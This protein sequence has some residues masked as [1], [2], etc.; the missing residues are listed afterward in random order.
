RTK[1]FGFG[2]IVGGGI[3]IKG[4]GLAIFIEARYHF[5]LVNIVKEEESQYE[6]LE[7]IKPNSQAILLGFK[8]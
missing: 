1:R 2:V 4:R 8:F 6:T 7:S 3:E 5:G